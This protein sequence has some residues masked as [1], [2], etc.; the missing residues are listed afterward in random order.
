M[1]INL[2]F[3]QLALVMLIYTSRIE[4][5][6]WFAQLSDV[7]YQIT[8]TLTGIKLLFVFCLTASYVL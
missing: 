3:I 1:Q 7:P 5:A 6:Y 8:K 4:F 2:D